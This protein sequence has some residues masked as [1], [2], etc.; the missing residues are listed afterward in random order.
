MKKKLFS[1]ILILVLVLGMALSVSA[2]TDSF[3]Y[4]DAGLLSAEEAA[5][6]EQRLAQL[7]DTYDAQIVVVTLAE[8]DTDPV[9]LDDYIYD[10]MG[11]GYGAGYDGVM[12]LMC[13]DVREYR[14]ISNGWCGEAITSDNIDS[15]GDVIVPDLSGGY[16]ADAFHA[17][18]DECEYYMDGY[19]NGYPFEFG[20]NLIIALAIGLVVGLITATVLKAQ[21]KS[22]RSQDRAHNYVK[23]GSLDLRVQNEVF[24]YQDV[25]RVPKPSESSDS[26]SHSSGGGSR[27]SGGGSF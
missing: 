10:S 14:I 6:L 2:A 23:A 27:S 22:V 9:L 15:I 25:Q 24:L 1:L 21:L 19:I 3:V 8:T 18:A 20:I 5:S 26:Y 16:Y 7:S 13:M 4:D 12:L 11:F 17:F